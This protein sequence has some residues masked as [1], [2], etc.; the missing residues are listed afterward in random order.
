MIR[1]YKKDLDSFKMMKD[2]VDVH[3]PGSTYY[4]TKM[5]QEEKL[6]KRDEREKKY[7]LFMHK[8]K[9]LESIIR[10]EYK[11]E[12]YRG[13]TKYGYISG[14]L[15]KKYMVI[16]TVMAVKRKDSELE[17]IIKHLIIDHQ[18][19]EIIASTESEAYEKLE[20]DVEGK[21]YVEMIKEEFQD[22]KSFTQF[23]TEVTIFEE[24]DDHVI[25]GMYAGPIY[26]AYKISR[27][28]I[29]LIESERI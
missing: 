2:A 20:H 23:P 7:E 28:K 6:E 22:I 5:L 18:K 4:H 10:S 16:T 25:I 8:F 17:C 12:S 15:G 19:K 11:E 24:E 9:E 27:D 13:P 3:V 1:I 21:P 29:E 14:A 26:L